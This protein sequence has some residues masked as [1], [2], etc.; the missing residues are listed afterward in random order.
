[1]CLTC[2]DNWLSFV[3]YA[4][5]HHG[6][7]KGLPFAENLRQNKV[8]TSKTNQNKTKIR[9]KDLF[10][11]YLHKL[12]SKPSYQI[13]CL[14]NI[15]CHQTNERY[16]NPLKTFILP[17]HLPTRQY[18]TVQVP[19]E[20]KLCYQIF[21][22]KNKMRRQVNDSS[23][24]SKPHNWLKEKSR[25]KRESL[26]GIKPMPGGLVCCGVC[27]YRL[28]HH[29]CTTKCEIQ[30]NRYARIEV[31]TTKDRFNTNIEVMTCLQ[32]LGAGPRGWPP[33]T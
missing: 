30:P 16:Y 15:I 8:H 1:M 22:H 23:R 17:S 18:D 20:Q 28:R 6:G 29:F 25:Q 7:L 9:T 13:K 3:N 5:R 26:A 2:N 19:Q 24:H 14:E 31:R 12:A 32:E 21:W 27:L 11:Y 10:K 33:T 4:I